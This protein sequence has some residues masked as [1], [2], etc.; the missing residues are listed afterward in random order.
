[1]RRIFSN[2]SRPVKQ[3]VWLPD[4][5][6]ILALIYA[7]PA[8]GKDNVHFYGVLTADTCIIAPGKE[9]I[10]LEFG[11]IS[12]KELYNNRRTP[13]K[14]FEVH[15]EECDLSAGSN[16]AITFKGDENTA[17]PGFL[18]L[19]DSSEAQGVAIGLETL[20]GKLIPVKK[21]SYK[22]ELQAGNNIIVLQ[23]FIQ[24]EPQ[25]VADKKIKQGK[26]QSSAM[27]ELSYY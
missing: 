23:A 14:R 16:V 10:P 2:C 9:L 7:A 26:F 12:V 6:L 18:A 11:P 3:P 13:G 24:G 1:M 8:T 21:E 20:D 4:L 19:K 25:A 15:L 22:Y 17:L 27:V 5:L